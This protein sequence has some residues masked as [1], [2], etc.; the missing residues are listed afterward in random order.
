MEIVTLVP[1]A[2][3]VAAL[4]VSTWTFVRRQKSDEFRVALD[5]NSKLEQSLSELVLVSSNERRSKTLEYLSIWEFFAFLVNNKE[6]KNDSIQKF[7]KPSLVK[8]IERIFQEYPDL[9]KNTEAYE[10]TKILLKKWK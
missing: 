7:F 9:A 4:A 2:I 8:E 3:S 6:I 10:E 5:I 1:I